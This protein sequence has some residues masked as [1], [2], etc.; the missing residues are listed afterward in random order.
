MSEIKDGERLKLVTFPSTE[1]DLLPYMD[2]IVGEIHESY[3]QEKHGNW[4]GNWSEEDQLRV[5]GVRATSQTIK[6]ALDSWKEENKKDNMHIDKN[7]LE[8]ENAELRAKLDKIQEITRGHIDGHLIDD[9]PLYHQNYVTEIAN[10]SEPS[11][12]SGY[13]FYT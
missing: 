3:H 7:K 6:E 2:R 12:T 4:H 5:E 9:L 8:K 10:L 1:Q 13:I 11:P